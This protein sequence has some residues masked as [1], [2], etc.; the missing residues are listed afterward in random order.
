MGDCHKSPTIILKAFVY[1]K[2]NKFRMVL[3]TVF[4]HT[5]KAI[6]LVVF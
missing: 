5:D 4:K 6:V 3:K 2:M 1:Y